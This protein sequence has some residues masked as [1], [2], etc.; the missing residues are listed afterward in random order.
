MNPIIFDS[1]LPP[2]E[3]S[4][5]LPAAVNIR[6]VIIPITGTQSL[7]YLFMDFTDRDAANAHFRTYFNENTEEMRSHFAEYLSFY[8]PPP[9][10]SVRSSGHYYT[11][12][13]AISAP[14][15]NPPAAN[16]SDR[17]DR[18]FRNYTATLSPNV[19]GSIVRVGELERLI[20]PFEHFVKP[21]PAGFPTTVFGSGGVI[22]TGDTS[23][24]AHP[25]G[26]S[27]IVAT[28]N[29]TVNRDFSGLIIAGG[30]VEFTNNATLA[31]D[32]FA[33]V[34]ALR[35][36]CADGHMLGS[37]LNNVHIPEERDEHASDT[38]WDLSQIVRYV[39]WSRSA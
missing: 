24:S 31:A 3:P 23:V 15:L 28:G 37:Y 27:V 8:R 29:V 6:R 33:V 18:M 16:S 10:A 4:L 34:S 13:D 32:P 7:L 14:A 2:P 36:R 20:T 21:L 22:V 39:N 12:A 1:S 25:P 30:T 11:A 5:N 35:E 19:P 26:L 38:R 9:V 17:L